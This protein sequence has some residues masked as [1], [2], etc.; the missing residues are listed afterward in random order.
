MSKIYSM[1]WDI[2]S[3][4]SFTGCIFSTIQE[5]IKNGMYTIQFFMGDPK[6]A[7][8][9]EIIN[10]DDIKSTKELIS[11]FPMN[12]FTHYPFCANLAGKAK[13]GELAWNG[14]FSI[15]RSLKNVIKCLEYE[16][17]VIAN[18]SKNRS[19]VVIHPGSYP[20]RDEGHKAVAKT[21]NYINFP[22]NS[23]LLLENCAGEGNKLCR[24][25]KEIQSIF[26]LIYSEKKKHV[27]VCVD[28]AHIWGQGD[29]NLREIEEIDRMFEDFEQLLGIENFY[30]LH[31][32]DSGV[33]LGKKKDVHVCLGK[34]E[35]WNENFDS[36]IHLLN[37]CKNFQ[38]PVV[39]ETH[40]LDMITLVQ[41]QP[42]LE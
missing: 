24:T 39:L 30:L 1:Y 25:F 38:I 12:I 2:G 3:H 6:K 16:L 11:H 18:F 23:H 36:L 28:T 37:K 31:L 32:N 9:R 17:G 27:K 29:Y 33:S 21:I 26:N 4:T 13:K 15:D 41:I 19:G 34:G 5:G 20:D 22:K 40:I 10:D 42:V 35:I 14:N 7:W 8:N